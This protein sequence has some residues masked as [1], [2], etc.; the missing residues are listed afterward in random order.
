MEDNAETRSAADVIHHLD[1]IEGELDT[2]LTTVLCDATLRDIIHDNYCAQPETL[3]VIVLVESLLVGKRFILHTHP[4]KMPELRIDR[5]LLRIIVSNAVSNA[6]KYGQ[7]GGQI[8]ITLKYVDF[9]FLLSITNMPGEGH[10]ALLPQDT[11]LVFQKGH[12]LHSGNDDDCHRTISSG[13]G[14]WIMEK[15]ATALGG[16]CDLKILPTYTEFT[17]ALPTTAD[18]PSATMISSFVLPH[19]AHIVF[20][21][22]CPLQRALFMAQQKPVFQSGSSCQSRGCSATE[23]KGFCAEMSQ[24]ISSRPT[25]RFLFISDENLDYICEETGLTEMMSGSMILREMREKVGPEIEQNI[26]A[27]VRSANDSKADIDEYHQRAHGFISKG[28]KRLDIREQLAG[29]WYKRFGVCE[30]GNDMSKER[31]GEMGE[32]AVWLLKEIEDKLQHFKHSLT[33]PN[34]NWHI[35]WSYL[36]SMKGSLMM[37]EHPVGTPMSAQSNSVI[38]LI[39]D[40]RSSPPSTC[41]EL[42]EVLDPIIKALTEILEGLKLLYE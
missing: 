14:A 22:D 19:D 15:C 29:M 6:A 9:S 38:K 18:G 13:D 27:V 1:T 33:Q 37:V 41:A 24:Y 20:L 26:L 40:S 12:R 34:V 36:H 42:K 28:A 4:K 31:F 7:V 32:S 5:Q 11:S 16:N 35:V 3:N 21:D 23:I 10:E 8:V 30:Q 39:A 2:T 17:L 25:D